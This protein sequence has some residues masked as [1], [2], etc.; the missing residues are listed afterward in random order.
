MLLS[1]IYIR[2]QHIYK[3]VCLPI[4][5]L[6]ITHGVVMTIFYRFLTTILQKKTRVIIFLFIFYFSFMP[7]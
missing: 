3:L 5:I 6:I 1:L 7:K 4:T 2:K